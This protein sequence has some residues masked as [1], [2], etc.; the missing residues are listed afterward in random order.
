MTLPNT[1]ETISTTSTGSVLASFEG[2]AVGN[3]VITTEDGTETATATI[4]GIARFGMEEGRG[5]GIAL[6]DTNSTGRLAPLDGMILL[7]QIEIP[8][9]ETAPGIVTLWEWQSGI[10]LP[11][12]T[13]PGTTTPEEL[14]P[15]M[16]DTTTTTTTNATTTT[17]DTGESIAA[18]PEEGGE[19]EE[20]QQQQQQTTPTIPPNPLFE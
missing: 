6:M 1:T 3:E 20:Q 11:T 19:G 5:I 4:F 13:I 10:P 8:P 2:T 9:E 16:D 18:I 12:G 15:Q 14:P 17:A 7:G